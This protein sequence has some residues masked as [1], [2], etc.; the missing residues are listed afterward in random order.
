MAD[1]PKGSSLRVAFVGLGAMGLPMAKN[2]ARAG[3][4]LTVWNRTAATAASVVE[5]G[6]SAADTPAN[7]AAAADVTLLC[8]PSSPE[9]HD[10]LTRPDGVLAGAARGSIVID[11]STIDPQASRGFSALCAEHGVDFLEAPLSGG[12]IGATNG[13]LTLMIGGDAA[14]LERARPALQAVGKNLFHVGGPG[15]GQTVKLCNQMIFAAQ[16]VAVSEA[17][18]LLGD[19]GIDA[20][21]ATEIF[22]VSTADCTAVRG[23]VP[24]AGVQPNAPAS[25]N[26]KPGFA[27]EWMAKDLHLVEELARSLTRFVPQAALNHQ[28]MRLTMEAGYAKQDLSVLG[29]VLSSFKR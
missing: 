26:W 24:V 22:S 6:A 15:A 28:L 10:I 18:T 14:V 16:V 4:P 17:Y 25:N 20:A 9:V 23:R 5:L 1:S 29:E 8:L 3:F 11:C 7:A 2:L 19:A 12:T 27:T 21:L 13:T